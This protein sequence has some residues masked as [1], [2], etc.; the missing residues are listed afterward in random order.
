MAWI[1]PVGDVDGPHAPG[2]LLR[3][4]ADRCDPPQGEEDLH[5]A[6]RR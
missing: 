4:G 2:Q 1:R 3:E 6:G 5:G